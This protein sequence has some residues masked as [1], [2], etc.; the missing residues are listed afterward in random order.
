[1]VTDQEKQD[2]MDEDGAGESSGPSA[3]TA[4]ATLAGSTIRAASA[5]AGGDQKRP[6]NTKR[7]R[8]SIGGEGGEIIG[9]CI[10]GTRALTMFFGMINGAGAQGPDMLEENQLPVWMM[11]ATAF[12]AIGLWELL[13]RCSHGRGV[14]PMEVELESEKGKI[15]DQDPKEEKGSHQETS[16]TD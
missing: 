9:G 3:S 16:A 7:T 8:M 1:M 10:H 4:T 13:R 14:S 2:E 15:Q 6:R 12:L 11:I 5:P